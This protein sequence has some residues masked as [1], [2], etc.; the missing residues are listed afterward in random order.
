MAGFA[1]LVVHDGSSSRGSLDRCDGPN[2]SA[3]WAGVTV[4]GVVMPGGC[5]SLEPGI[6]RCR[7]WS[8]GPSRND[9]AAGS[10]PN[11]GSHILLGAGPAFRRHRPLEGVALLQPGP[12]GGDVRPEIPSQPD[13]FRQPQ[14]V[15]VDDI[16]R[17]EAPGA[18]RLGFSGRG[19]NRPQP[20]QKPF[21]VIAGD[22][23]VAALL[24]LALA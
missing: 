14:G 2:H 19:L 22:L 15:A 12:I 3:N 18:Q 24:R 10:V 7:I 5:E 20:A 21:G 17:G 1:A 16:G 8:F 23:R 13:I 11:P 9:G 6:S 4:G